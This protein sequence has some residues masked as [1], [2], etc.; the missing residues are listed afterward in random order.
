MK[1][2]YVIYQV[3]SSHGLAPRESLHN[4]RQKKFVLME[5]DF[6]DGNYDA[7]CNSME[8]AF[9]KIKNYGNDYT[10]YTVLP[11]IYLTR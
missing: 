7:N 9:E 3:D 6:C 2:Q 4:D 10:E 5:A 8:Q 11:R 1:I